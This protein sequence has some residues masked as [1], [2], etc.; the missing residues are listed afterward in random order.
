MITS[1]GR[2]GSS[3]VTARETS[4]PSTMRWICSSSGEPPSAYPP[5]TAR[6]TV[7]PADQ[8]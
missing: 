1:S 3:S 8:S 2:T 5:A 6:P 4:R 7:I